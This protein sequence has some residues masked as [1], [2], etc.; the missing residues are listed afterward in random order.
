MEP[1]QRARELL[2]DIANRVADLRLA[3]GSGRAVNAGDVHQLLDIQEQL[4]DM[5][6]NVADG[7]SQAVDHRAPE[8]DH[9]A[10]V[11]STL[12]DMVRQIS[13]RIAAMW[14]AD[15]VSDY[16]TT[17][18]AELARAVCNELL[19]VTGAASDAG[20]LCPLCRG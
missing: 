1:T 16:G 3:I 17:V 10:Y 5:A 12:S 18:R 19:T 20:C 4:V 2:D 13:L 8:Q 9:R 15:A 6:A 14:P 7:R 11:D